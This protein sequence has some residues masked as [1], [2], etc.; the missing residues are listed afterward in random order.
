MKLRELKIEDAPL[1]LEWM[2]DEEVVR[3]L[4]KD[5]RSMTLDDCVR[6]IEMSRIASGLIKSNIGVNIGGAMHLA[7]AGDGDKYMGTVSLKEIDRKKGCAEFGITLR[8]EAMG[9][10]FASYA[11]QEIL[12]LGTEEMGINLIY[13]CVDPENER[14]IRFYE[15]NEYKRIDCDELDVKLEYTDKEKERYIWYAYRK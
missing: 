2:H 15:K 10:G 5:F 9:K 12:K 14:A 4:K 1:M 7:I 3:D 8:R 11:M 6:F 13:W